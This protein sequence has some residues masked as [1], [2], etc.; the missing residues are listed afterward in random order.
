[1][2]TLKKKKTSHNLTLHLIELGEKKRTRPKSTEG[3]KQNLN[4]NKS[5][6]K[7][8]NNRK[9]STKLRLSFLERISKTDK[10]LARLRKR[11]KTQV[12]KIRNEKETLQWMPQK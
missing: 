10:P 11:Q 6:S 3:R 5:N 2:P 12:N 8:K 9:K 4:R 1:M 7:Q